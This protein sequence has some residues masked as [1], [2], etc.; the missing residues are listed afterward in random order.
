MTS[1]Q[2][3]IAAAL[4]ASPL[5]FAAFEGMTARISAKFKYVGWQAI[6]LNGGEVYFGKIQSV[7]RNE[8]RLVNIYYIKSDGRPAGK[9]LDDY[10]EDLKLIKLGAELHGPK[11]VMYISRSSIHFTESLKDDGEVVKAI[12]RYGAKSLSQVKKVK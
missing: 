4:I 11:D 7:S 6:F 10:A 9:S 1:N 8:I 5:L 12:T 2:L 3:T